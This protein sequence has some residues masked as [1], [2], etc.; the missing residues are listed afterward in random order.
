MRIGEVGEQEE[1]P[2]IDSGTELG[3]F[4]A[5]ANLRGFFWCGIV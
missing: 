3:L 1:N 4:L 5:R 2:G